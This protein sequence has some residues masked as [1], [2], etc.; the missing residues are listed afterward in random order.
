MDI[1]KELVKEQ[2]GLTGLLKETD[3]RKTHINLTQHL[4]NCGLHNL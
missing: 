1:G 4:N 3:L 2:G